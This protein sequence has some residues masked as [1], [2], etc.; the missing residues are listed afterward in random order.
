MSPRLRLLKTDLIRARSLL[1]KGLSRNKNRIKI[2]LH[3]R[4][5]EI[6]EQFKSPSTHWSKRFMNWLKSIELYESSTNNSLNLLISTSEDL[7]VTV[8]KATKKI[9]EML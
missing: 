1:V 8:L 5:I 4:G 9:S 6:P 2:F 3:F 7:R